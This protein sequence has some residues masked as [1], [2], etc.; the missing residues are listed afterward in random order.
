MNRAPLAPLQF[1]QPR[2]RERL[3]SNGLPRRAVGDPRRPYA[4]SELGIRQRLEHGEG[5]SRSIVCGLRWRAKAGEPRPDARDKIVNPGGP[6]VLMLGHLLSDFDFGAG[7]G[8]T[9]LQ[10]PRGALSRRE[11]H[12][13]AN[14]S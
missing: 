2:R 11:M 12:L 6:P 9:S 14:E 10:E 8:Q 7:S 1:M 5:R 4:P 3:A 13:D